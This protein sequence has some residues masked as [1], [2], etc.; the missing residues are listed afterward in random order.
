MRETGEWKAGN[1]HFMLTYPHASWVT[2]A[3]HLGIVLWPKRTKMN[4]KVREVIVVMS[5]GAEMYGE[6]KSSSSTKGL[7]CPCVAPVMI[8]SLFNSLLT[9]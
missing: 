1:H 6:V 9:L 5:F 3:Y 8:I 2:R 7:L 4:W